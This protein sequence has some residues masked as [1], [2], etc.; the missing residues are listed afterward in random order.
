MAQQQQLQHMQAQIDALQAQ[1]AQAQPQAAQPV[2]VQG[3]VVD[4]PQV[5]QPAP[6]MVNVGQ[7]EEPAVNS[8]CQ[9]QIKI[10]AALAVVGMIVGA[11]V[12]S[13]VDH[14]YW[15]SLASA[16]ENPDYNIAADDNVAGD[17]GTNTIFVSFCL[18]CLACC[19]WCGL[20]AAKVLAVLSLL[21]F[22]LSGVAYTVTYFWAH[23]GYVGIVWLLFLGLFVGSFVCCV[24]GCCVAC[25]QGTNLA[26]EIQ[27]HESSESSPLNQKGQCL[28]CVW[29]LPCCLYLAT[30]IL[31]GKDGYV[32][33]GLDFMILG[34]V[35]PVLGCCHLMFNACVFPV[36]SEK[37]ERSE[38]GGTESQRPNPHSDPV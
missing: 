29:A 37:G 35:A 31:N 8:D 15:E 1:L 22:C 33:F 6:A 24:A 34:F 2:V 3:I 11:V 36:Q 19:C 7:P 27:Q 30:A 23:S 9:L 13:T 20:G 16:W 4:E 5:V 32:V 26:R 14:T 25:F 21:A 28:V 10:V 17:I 18:L 38:E 12:L